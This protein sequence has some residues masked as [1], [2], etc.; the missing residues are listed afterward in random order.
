[1]GAQLIIMQIIVHIIRAKLWSFRNYELW[2]F[3]QVSWNHRSHSRQVTGARCTEVAARQSRAEY[4]PKPTNSRHRGWAIKKIPVLSE[5]RSICL[6]PLYGIMLMILHT[7][8]QCVLIS[9]K[10]LQMFL[11]PLKKSQ[12]FGTL[13]R[14]F[15]SLSNV[16]VI[17]RILTGSAL[18]E[19]LWVNDFSHNEYHIRH[20]WPST[21]WHVG[22]KLPNM[23]YQ[24]LLPRSHWRKSKGRT[25]N[26]L[27]IWSD[28]ILCQCQ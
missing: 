4:S 5:M 22:N 8:K 16:P 10:N 14:P 13:A 20:V 17:Q 15:H 23:K 11:S 27:P 21:C 24:S 6:Q 2:L 26:G 28:W 1:M 19:W 12:C 25:K 3:C 7:N 9:D 18:I